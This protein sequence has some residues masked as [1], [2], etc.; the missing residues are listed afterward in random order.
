MP[1]VKFSDR[2]E[3]TIEMAFSSQ[4][5]ASDYQFLG[6]VDE[7]DERYVKF[8]DRVSPKSD[9][10][11]AGKPSLNSLLAEASSAISPLLLSIQL[12]EA[13][14]EEIELAKRW[15][16]YVRQ[17]KLVDIASSPVS[18]PEKPDTF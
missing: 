8:L 10:M 17:L 15:Q 18:W 2:A 5:S 14:Q 3:S 7:S 1:F 11:A 6:M 16:D 9:P 12:G 13:T 4:Q